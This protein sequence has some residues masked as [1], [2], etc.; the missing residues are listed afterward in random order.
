MV[1]WPP[2]KLLGGGGG[3]GG[4]CP[5]S[6]YA[7]ELHTLTHHLVTFVVCFLLLHTQI[8]AKFGMWADY[9]DG[10]GGQRLC[11]PPPPTF[12]LKLLGGGGGGGL[13][14]PFPTPTFPNSSPWFKLLFII[15]FTIM[16]LINYLHA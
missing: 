1:C 16:Q 15:Y 11:C 9:G 7:Y 2:L 3:G 6:S 12:S 13:P 4:G 5:L 10:K 8:E 14:S